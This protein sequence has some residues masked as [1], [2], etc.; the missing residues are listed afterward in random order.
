VHEL[1]NAVYTAALGAPQREGDPIPMCVLV[2]G[3]DEQLLSS[4][5][6]AM[7]VP[8]QVRAW[9]TQ[10]LLR[11][12]Q[13]L[14][15]ADKDAAAAYNWAATTFLH[16]T[17]Q[18][19]NDPVQRSASIKQL[20]DILAENMSR[21]SGSPKSPRHVSSE[22]AAATQQLKPWVL[23][24][25]GVSDAPKL[26]PGWGG[27]GTPA[28]SVAALRDLLC[29]AGLL[30]QAQVHGGPPRA[31]LP[32][33]T[34]FISPHSRV[35]ILVSGGA[36]YVTEAAR[37]LKHRAVA[38]GT[39]VLG[40]GA[41]RES[42]ARSSNIDLSALGSRDLR[43]SYETPE[44]ARMH[45]L[46]C[47][48]VRSAQT[49]RSRHES[50]CP[51]YAREHNRLLQ[52][53]LAPMSACTLLRRTPL[54]QACA[55]ELLTVE[56]GRRG[57]LLRDL[58]ALVDD[59]VVAISEADLGGATRPDWAPRVAEAAQ[60]LL[61]TLDSPRWSWDI[62]AVADE[63]RSA[64]LDEVYDEDGWKGVERIEWRASWVA[65]VDPLCQKAR[66]T[67]N[68]RRA[69]ELRDEEITKSKVP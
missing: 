50:V 35:M 66:D 15:R 55:A 38:V 6:V 16:W 44:A 43:S 46:A 47:L 3:Y 28:V 59:C 58:F 42:A 60:A 26:Q 2:L 37:S 51:P 53:L 19:L 54:L 39:A 17:A 12:E 10:R 41:R 8:L 1:D 5:S 48:Q 32:A 63:L 40:D 34:P 27:S 67:Y 30:P 23:V 68:Q 7:A 31:V 52:L 4:S 56:G 45:A 21:S 61:T 33:P 36:M 13:A 24:I 49:P 25:S 14:L 57:K 20:R 9:C 18:T 22:T 69:S 65:E 29:D 62:D 11:E 64:V